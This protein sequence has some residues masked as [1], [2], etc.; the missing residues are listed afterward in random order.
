LLELFEFE[1]IILIFE[2][3]ANLVLA[4]VCLIRLVVVIRE[5]VTWN[6]GIVYVF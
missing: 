3:A 2:K 6:D 4:V 1:S 5:H